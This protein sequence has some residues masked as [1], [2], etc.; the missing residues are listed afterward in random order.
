ML[1][2]FAFDKNSLDISN[3]NA[4]DEVLNEYNIDCII[5]AAAYTNVDQAEINY[6]AALQVNGSSIKHLSSSCKD[7]GILLIHFSTDYVFNGISSMPYLP[8]STPSPINKYGVT[9]LFGEKAILSSGLKGVILRT[10]WVFSPFNNNFLIKILSLARTEKVLNII[11][12]QYGCPT[13][14]FDIAKISHKIALNYNKNRTTIYHLG[15]LPTTTWFDFAS[16]IIEGALERELIQSKPTL[17]RISTK[18]FKT[19]AKRPLFSCLDSRDL[20]NDFSIDKIEWKDG[21]DKTLDLL[22]REKK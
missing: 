10:S 17:N 18:E 8:S 19:L 1:I 20:L 7:R 21:V 6:E 2:F 4:I 13:Y 5:N 9:K 12:D 3:P 15:G 14:T 22:C 16:Y 11:D